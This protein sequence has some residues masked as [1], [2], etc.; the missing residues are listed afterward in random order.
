MYDIP[1]QA[2]RLCCDRCRIHGRE[3]KQCAEIK[4]LYS[5]S[6]RRSR[7]LQEVLARIKSERAV[8]KYM[9]NRPFVEYV[10]YK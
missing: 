7:F 1:T 3:V 10:L 2:G 4:S 6:H 8:F 5:A 9:G